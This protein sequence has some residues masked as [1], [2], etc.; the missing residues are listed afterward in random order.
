M[1]II[2]LSESK[3]IVKNAFIKKENGEYYYSLDLIKEIL[4]DKA[5][6]ELCGYTASLD[7][8]TLEEVVCNSALM[9]YD[10][11]IAPIELR[12]NIC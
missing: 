3:D 12:I 7:D 11:E 2:V 5:M 1:S 6:A 8:E 9:E 10:M 4:F